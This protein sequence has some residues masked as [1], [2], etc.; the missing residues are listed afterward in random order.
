MLEIIFS[1]QDAAVMWMGKRAKSKGGGCTSKYPLLCCV[2]EDLLPHSASYRICVAGQPQPL[3]PAMAAPSRPGD[4]QLH[5]PANPLHGAETVH[6]AFGFN[7]ELMY[8]EC[9]LQAGW[10]WGGLL[11]EAATNRREPLSP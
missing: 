9:S 11:W 8:S 4:R 5:S 3:L 2:T 10:A 6:H 7:R 1:G